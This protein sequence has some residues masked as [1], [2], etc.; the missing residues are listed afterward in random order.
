[1]KVLT[2]FRLRENYRGLGN[3]EDTDMADSEGRK[4]YEA[5]RVKDL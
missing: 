2:D 4:P 5:I 1:M 3:P